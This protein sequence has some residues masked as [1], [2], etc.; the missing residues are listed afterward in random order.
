MHKALA[1]REAIRQSSAQSVRTLMHLLGSDF[2]NY[3][4]ASSSSDTPQNGQ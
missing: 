2:L 1:K 3:F 4:C